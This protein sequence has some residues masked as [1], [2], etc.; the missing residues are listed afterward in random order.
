MQ[1]SSISDI[2]TDTVTAAFRHKQ[3]LLGL[4][5]VNLLKGEESG[6]KWQFVS[7]SMFTL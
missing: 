6:I 3:A 7:H 2:C 1:E 5:Y 4:F